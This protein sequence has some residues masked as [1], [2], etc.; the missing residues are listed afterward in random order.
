M[1]QEYLEWYQN[2]LRP[3]VKQMV[4]FTVT[5]WKVGIASLRID[6]E[7]SK[8]AEDEKEEENIQHMTGMT[9][10]SH[11]TAS[12]AGAT[13]MSHVEELEGESRTN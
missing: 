10:K 3:C 5:R 2:T 7:E 13:P 12:S 6:T 4:R 8:D 9:P 1:I 11:M